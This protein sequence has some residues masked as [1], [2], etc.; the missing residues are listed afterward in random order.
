VTHGIEFTHVEQQA[1]LPDRLTHADL[2]DRVNVTAVYSSAWAHMV[3]AA[4]VVDFVDRNSP[5]LPFRVLFDK[6]TGPPGETERRLWVYD[7]RRESPDPGKEGTVTVTDERLTLVSDPEKARE[8]FD[9]R[10]THARENDRVR[11]TVLWATSSDSEAGNRLG[12]TGVVHSVDASDAYLTFSVRF[13]DGASFWYYDVETVGVAFQRG[14]RVRS[15]ATS[16][17]GT[18]VTPHELTPGVVWDSAPTRVAMPRVDVLEPVDSESDKDE[19]IRLLTAQA[20]QATEQL[21]AFK[22]RVRQEALDVASRMGWCDDGLNGTLENLGL[23]LKDKP[24]WKAVVMVRVEVTGIEM[25]EEP[26][27][28]EVRRGLDLGDIG[29]SG[30]SY[31]EGDDTSVGWDITEI[32]VERE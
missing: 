16:D 26:S 14:A 21:A 3:G 2:G 11:P 7:V 24:K 13:D 29:Y 19:R 25:D 27:E 18:V 31:G 22:D 10:K 6:A 1:S 8:T 4:G 28:N 17:L 5:Q 32:D 12:T 23:P 30:A 9:E 15:T 20:S